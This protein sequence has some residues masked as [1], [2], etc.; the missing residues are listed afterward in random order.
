MGF[1]GDVGWVW[2]TWRLE[3]QRRDVP[4]RAVLC[5]A[6]PTGPCSRRWG[7][8]DVFCRSLAAAWM[9]LPGNCRVEAKREQSRSCRD[10][11]SS[12]S[13]QNPGQWGPPKAVGS[14]AVSPVPNP[15]PTPGLP[16]G[17]VFAGGKTREKGTVTSWP[18]QRVRGGAGG[19]G[20]GQDGCSAPRGS[21]AGGSA[22]GKRH[23]SPCPAPEPAPAPV[24]ARRGP[25]QPGRRRKGGVWQPPRPAHPACGGSQPEGCQ[26]GGSRTHPRLFPT[27]QQVQRAGPGVRGWVTPQLG[28]CL[29]CRGHWGGAA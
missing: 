2:R 5:R 22:P 7:C 20:H 12:I 21:A 27:L 8:G 6:V 25:F 14:L 1:F 19:S 29:P 15:H 18:V 17:R 4:G 24:P 11:R 28:M 9:E 10:P 16:Q 13:T 23:I 3:E 26:G